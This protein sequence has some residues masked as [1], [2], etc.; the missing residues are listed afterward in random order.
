MLKILTNYAAQEHAIRWQELVD[1]HSSSADYPHCTY[2]IFAL[3]SEDSVWVKVGRSYDPRNRIATYRYSAHF[4]EFG[5]VRIVGVVLVGWGTHDES[6]LAER[7]IHKCLKPYRYD[8]R[9]WFTNQQSGLSNQQFVH[10]FDFYW[11]SL[12][13]V[14]ATYEELSHGEREIL[15][16][17]GGFPVIARVRAQ[18]V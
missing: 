12:R 5:I 18:R 7:Y 13:H 2:G 8:L 17:N 6:R 16:G 10:L 15:S 4:R 14:G 11:A 3:D 1:A 9:E